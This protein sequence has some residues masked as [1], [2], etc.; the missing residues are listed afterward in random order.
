MNPATASID[1]SQAQA[2]LDAF[3][4]QGETPASAGRS[5]LEMRLQDNGRGIALNLG[6]GVDRG[7]GMASMKH[8]A[9]QMQ[10]QCLVESGAGLGT[11]IRLTLPLQ[12]STTA[13]RAAATM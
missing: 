9:R 11:I 3:T 8:R 10:G 13:G 2:T 5:V 6:G 4:R 12:S 1:R 7:H